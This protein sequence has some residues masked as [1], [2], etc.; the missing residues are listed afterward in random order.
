MKDLFECDCC[1]AEYTLIWSRDLR[2]HHRRYGNQDIMED[3]D[4]FDVV[5]NETPSFCAFCGNEF[6]N[7]Y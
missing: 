3:D 4:E 2:D 1:G 6:N 7:I 5:K